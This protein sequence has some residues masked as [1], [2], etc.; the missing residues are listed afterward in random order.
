MNVFGVAYQYDTVMENSKEDNVAEFLGKFFWKSDWIE[1]KSKIMAER[2]LQ[3]RKEITWPRWK[4]G[5]HGTVLLAPG[6]R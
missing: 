6:G 2:Q 4:E 1:S 3:E 5:I